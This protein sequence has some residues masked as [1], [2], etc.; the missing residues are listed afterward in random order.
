[1]L[2]KQKIKKTLV[3]AAKKWQISS[4]RTH[5]PNVGATIKITNRRIYNQ[6]SKAFVYKEL[7]REI[8]TQ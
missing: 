1:L 6:L 2:I 7:F 4:K 5:L 3:E 8:I